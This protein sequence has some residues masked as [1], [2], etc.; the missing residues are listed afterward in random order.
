MNKSDIIDIVSKVGGL[1]KKTSKKVVDAILENM[2]F[3]LFKGESINL[4]GF[5]SLKS[6]I[7]KSRNCRNPQTGEMV[8]IPSKKS[9][10]FK[11]SKEFENTLNG[12]APKKKTPKP[13]D[14]EKYDKL[15]QEL[16]ECISNEDYET[17][18]IIRDKLNKMV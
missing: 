7:K 4:S 18:S 17:A 16:N 9:A 8:T 10:K 11:L 15:N 5:F 13:F 1:D 3:S 6:I 14:K 12:I 2:K